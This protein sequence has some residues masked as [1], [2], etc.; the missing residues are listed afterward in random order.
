MIGKWPQIPVATTDDTANA[1]LSDVVGSKADAA[2]EDKAATASLVA[3]AKGALDMMARQIYEVK[4]WSVVTPLVTVTATAADYALGDV[5]LEAGA[6][7]SG[8][9]IKRAYAV[10]KIRD[11]ENTNG[12]ANDIDG[13]VESPA[14]QVR[15]DTPGAW[16]DAILLLEK[17][18][19]IPAT[20][21][22][23]G[24]LIIG[25]IDIKATVVGDDTYN[26]Q[27]DQLEAALTNLL[28]HDVQVGIV[29][30]YTLT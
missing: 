4:R 22:G 19:A 24:D 7:P 26:T 18:W 23:A 12:S 14:L 8:A 16:A 2:V 27:L 5:V 6:I 29:V 15:N 17:Q 3:Y 20:S 9:V 21:V 28:L 25:D 10:L 1:T 30:E 11:I 13:S